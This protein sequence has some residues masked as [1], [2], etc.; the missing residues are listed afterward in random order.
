MSTR[1]IGGGQVPVEVVDAVNTLLH[2]YGGEYVPRIG[3][4]DGK[5]VWL[6]MREACQY[7]RL[8]RWTIHRGIK[9]GALEAKRT[10]R[11]R[12]GKVLVRREDLDRWLSELPS[13][14]AGRTV[15]GGAR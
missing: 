10:H 5:Q 3:Q 15:K 14:G 11:S 12:C 6:S 2:P 9:D 7:S 13:C 8:S 4:D 1:N